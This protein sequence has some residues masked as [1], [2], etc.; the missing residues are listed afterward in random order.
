MASQTSVAT[1]TIGSEAIALSEEVVQSIAF[2]LED[3][4]RHTQLFA[5]LAKH[6]SCR[7]RQQVARND[8][9]DRPT[10]ELLARDTDVEVLRN[11][12]LSEAARRYLTL[13]MLVRMIELDAYLASA[14]AH[15]IDDFGLATTVQL[16]ERLMS[17]PDPI[18]RRDLAQADATP[19]RFVKALCKDPDLSVMMAAQEALA[20]R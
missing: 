8:K 17:H 13:D 2:A 5:E 9:L 16:A 14:L 1:L 4:E 10:V 15:R 7:V 6:P 12:V 18:V 19:K 3:H 20:N 11:L